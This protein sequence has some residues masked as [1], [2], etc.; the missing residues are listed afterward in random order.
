MKPVA[1]VLGYLLT[2]DDLPRYAK[3][4]R[5]LELVDGHLFVSALETPYLER[6]IANADRVVR[7]AARGLDVRTNQPIEFDERNL[8]IPDIAI[9]SDGPLPRLV[10]EVR[11][12]STERYALGP[13]RM[14]YARAKITE[15]WFLDPR[16][17]SVAVLRFTAPEPDYVWPPRYFHPGD[18]LPAGVLPVIPVAQLFG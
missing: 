11:S 4:D 9:L 13:K 17:S 5:R 12:D 3:P 6:F 8:L 1:R 7:A 15:Y 10:I 16:A 2:I 14:V 18:E